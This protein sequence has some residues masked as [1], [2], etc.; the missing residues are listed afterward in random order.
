MISCFSPR[1]VKINRED[2][3]IRGTWKTKNQPEE[4]VCISPKQGFVLKGKLVSPGIGT[5]P[6]VEG[7]SPS[8]QYGQPTI[9]LIPYKMTRKSSLDMILILTLMLISPDSLLEEYG[10]RQEMSKKHYWGE[11]SLISHFRV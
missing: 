4:M 11:K 5:S 9:S 6:R 8:Q 1:N 2:G 10:A 7:V 3:F